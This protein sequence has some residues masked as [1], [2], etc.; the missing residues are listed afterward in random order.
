M[1][2]TALQHSIVEALEKM[3]LLVIRIQCGRVKVRG[4]WMQLAPEGTP[5]LLVTGS[6]YLRKAFLET[7]TPVGKLSQVQRVMHQRLVRSGERVFVV[8]SVEEA[9]NAV[10]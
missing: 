2:E 5:D 4:G 3:G 8:R 6:K 9:I 7:K 10:R 1:S